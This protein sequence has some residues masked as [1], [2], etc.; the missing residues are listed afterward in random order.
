MPSAVT[1][2]MDLRKIFGFL[3]PM[4]AYGEHE[5]P[6]EE[7]PLPE[8]SMVLV[9]SGQVGYD[10]VN[11]KPK[12]R[13]KTGQKIFTDN[14]RFLRFSPVTGT[15]LDISDLTW[16]DGKRFTAITI[17]IEDDEYEYLFQG[18]EGFLSRTGPELV[19]LL[20]MASFNTGFTDTDLDG[21]IV[22]LLES[23]L[24]VCNIRN[25]LINFSA[26]IE[27]GLALL[28]RTT[29]NPVYI[30]VT[31]HN[32]ALVRNIL[33]SKEI[34]AAIR[35]ISSLYPRGMTELVPRHVLGGTGKKAIV[36]GADR[37][38]AMV[39]TLETGSCWPGRIITVIGR[40]GRPVK[41]LSVRVGTPVYDVLRNT[42]ISAGNG[43]KVTIGGAM[44]GKAVS[45]LDFPVTDDAHAVQIMDAGD[46]YGVTGSACMNCGKCVAVCPNKLPVNLLARYAEFALFERCA[47]LDLD[48]CIEC[49]LC[50]YVCSTRRPVVQYLLFAKEQ[51]RQRE[52]REGS[53]A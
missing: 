4:L 21:I 31:R 19:D 13:V 28:N 53:D 17:D 15:V 5:I 22:N 27:K 37:L 38:L 34:R 23:D 49:G 29:D 18:S 35:V 20:K 51:L 10:K 26:E 24:R 42:Y 39:K 1:V 6:F 47:E 50:S 11:L 2:M 3:P 8:T 25:I 32:E 48:Y 41:N 12:E 45:R 36:I 14:N 33:A 43:D 40:Y 46:I 30:A 16:I 9:D 44:R 52:L 7:L